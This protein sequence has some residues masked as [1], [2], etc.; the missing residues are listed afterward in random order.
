[1]RSSVEDEIDF[2]LALCWTFWRAFVLS[3]KICANTRWNRTEPSA[4]KME[5]L[6]GWVLDTQFRRAT[7]AKLEGPLDKFH[8]FI[9]RRVMRCICTLSEIPWAYTDTR[10]EIHTH[11][12]TQGHFG[13]PELSM[14]GLPRPLFCHPPLLLGQTL[15]Q[16]KDLLQLIEFSLIET[17]WKATGSAAPLEY[18]S[19]YL[20]LSIYI[21]VMIK[22][23]VLVTE[24]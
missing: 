17:R 22:S 19:F 23:N 4:N 21:V 16:I 11:T 14:G 8:I 10:R 6:D 12:H 2:R 13:W 15:A 5:G 1:M 7:N 18:P 3:S 20:I 24:Y 9:A